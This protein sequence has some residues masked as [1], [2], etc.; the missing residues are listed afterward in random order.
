MINMPVLPDVSFIETDAQTTIDNIIGT[1]EQL[2]GVSL[3]DGDP[4]RLFLLSLAYIIIQQRQQIDAAG[5][6]NLLY[7]AKDGFLDHIGAMRQTERLPA[8]GA[9][10]VQRFILSEA[11]AMP[12]GIPQGTR[13]TADGELYWATL[14]PVTI[15]AGV[16]YVDV[17]VQ[18]LTAGSV[19]NNIEAGAILELVDPIPFVQS[20]TNMQRT[21]GGSDKELDDDY[22]VRIYNAP[23]A[24]SIA[25]P[26]E[27]YEFWGYT[28][29][30]AISDVR[31]T[32]PV[33]GTVE[34]FVLLENG[35]IPDQPILD[36][37]YNVLSPDDIRPLTDNVIVSAPTP[38]DYSIEFTYFI[39][40][41]DSGGVAAIEQRVNNA[42]ADYIK[43]QRARIG[44]DINPDDLITRVKAAGAKRLEIINPSFTRL[45]EG[46]AA[47]E[48]SVNFNYGGVEDE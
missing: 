32:T 28:A 45:T 2:A 22:R 12:I 40:T 4:R 43:W 19:G 6:S 8:S 13:V 47:Q 16:L 9:F 27:A 24:F 36:A 42:V 44:R 34:V 38:A 17:N 1:Y 7:Y 29:S 48:I 15:Q 35:E 46:E 20:T 33:P 5:K 10:T 39:R 21:Q 18:A 11:Q 26:A 30:S 41:V 37:V 25:G 31:A 23:A 3:A 14:E